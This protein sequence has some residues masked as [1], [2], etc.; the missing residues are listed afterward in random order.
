[1]L[2]WDVAVTH[3]KTPTPEQFQLFQQFPA[4]QQQALVQRVKG[5]TGC[6]HSRGA[7]R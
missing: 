1:M 2:L 7:G 3:A 6:R 5:G 4:E